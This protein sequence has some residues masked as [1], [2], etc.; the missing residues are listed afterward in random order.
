MA[1]ALIFPV[2]APRPRLGTAAQVAGQLQRYLHHGALIDMDA[3]G[4]ALRRIGDQRAPER[5]LVIS[6]R[7]ALEVQA[8]IDLC[9]TKIRCVR[10][11]DVA[12]H[13][14]VNIAP[15]YH[16]PWTVEQDRQ[17]RLALVKRQLETLRRRE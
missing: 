8:S 2:S 13:L 15:E 12:D 3:P 4:Q 1:Y 6:R 11:V 7:E 17:M 9:R 16:Q 14:V 10:D 5:H